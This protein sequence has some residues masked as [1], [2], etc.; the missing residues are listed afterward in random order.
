MA[1]VAMIDLRD[2]DDREEHYNFRTYVTRARL[3]KANGNAGNQ[4]IWRTAEPAPAGGP[5]GGATGQRAFETMNDWLAAIE[6]DRSSA[7]LEQKVVEHRPA[8]AVDTCF[9]NGAPVAASVCDAIYRTFTDTRVA[10]G[11]P[12]ASDIMKCQLKPLARADYRVTFTDAEW[13][14]LER[15]F[16]SGVCDFSKP[17]VDQVTPEPW[18]SFSNGPGGRPLGPVPVSQPVR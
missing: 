6:S 2:N 9:Q 14:M 18:Q 11:E 3:V 10:A 1:K 17:G 15:V 16:A 5:G 12:A 13:S 4:A 7:P 8:L